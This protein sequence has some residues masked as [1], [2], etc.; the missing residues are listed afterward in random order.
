MKA[1]FLGSSFFKGLY[2]PVFH[3]L[4]QNGYGHIEVHFA[5][6]KPEA[7]DEAVSKEYPSI[8]LNSNRGFND[9]T[10]IRELISYIRSK[11]IN[12]IF[13]PNIPI[14]ELSYLMKYFKIELP[15]VKSIDLLHSCTNF[16]VI[17]KVYQ[18]KEMNWRDVKSSKLAFQYIFPKLYLYLLQ[19]D[20]KR[21][22]RLSLK[23]FDKIITL[24]PHYVEDY[25]NLLDLAY[26][27]NKI[28]AIPNIGTVVEPNIP[29]SEKPK[30]IVFVGRLSI[31]KA[32][33][34]LLFI[35]KQ[36]MTSIPD[37]NL[38]IVGDGPERKNL[39]AMSAQLNLQNVEFIGF[40]A[41]LP[42]IDRA[43]ILCLVSNFEGF[44]TVF[45]EAMSLGVVPIGFDS[46]SAIHDMIDHGKNGMIIP[47]FDYERYADALTTLAKNDQMRIQMAEAAKL[48]VKEYNIPRIASLWY[49]LFIDMGLY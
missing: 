27:Q 45:T 13:N 17:N 36:T 42:F 2:E 31:E 48:K 9:N 21:R 30:Q 16:V 33:H 43:S 24:S 44:P 12:V 32:V 34:R 23:S 4:E 6:Y 11:E 7:I 47:C 19:Q 10:N 1:L 37:W 41:A 8:L 14:D 5:H 40:Q 20:V 46:F 25:C 29:I 18:L 39:E 15:N 26:S 49:N 3:Y 22:M 28:M 35:W 38:C